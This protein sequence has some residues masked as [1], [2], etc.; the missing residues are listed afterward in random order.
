[1]EFACFTSHVGL[2][3]ITLSS[4]KLH[5]DSNARMHAVRFSQLL[6]AP[7]LAALEMQIFVNNPQ[8]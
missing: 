2:L 1:M 8:N 7:F 6:S 4:L 5:T 3:V